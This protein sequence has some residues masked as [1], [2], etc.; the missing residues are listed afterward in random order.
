M[1]LLGSHAWRARATALL[2]AL[3]LGAVAV[4]PLAAQGSREGVP[5]AVERGDGRADPMPK[6]RG[7]SLFGSGDIATTGMKGVGAYSF[8]FTNYGPPLSDLGGIFISFY[9][10]VLRNGGWFN[11]YFEITLIAGAPR[12]EFR[13]IRNVH[14]AIG[15]FSSGNG[16]T[17]LWNAPLL[18]GIGEIAPSDNSLGT[19]FSGIQSTA[20][21]SC[22]DHTATVNEGIVAGS[23][24]L[25]GSDCPETWGTLGWQGPR[26]I[27]DTAFR[28]LQNELGDAFNW[29]YWRTDPAQR[30]GNLGNFSTFGVMT[31]HTQEMLQVYGGATPQGSGPSQVQ[32][33]P[34][35][36]DFRFEAASFSLPALANTY[37]Y[38]VL[39]INNS[40]DVYGTGI[41]YDS[42]YAGLEIG[43][44]DT[45][46][47][48]NTYYEPWRNAVM[49]A[50]NNINPNCNNARRSGTDTPACNAGVAGSGFTRGSSS[51]VMLKSPIGDMRNK[52]FT[53]PGAWNDPTH[54]RRADTITFNHGHKCGYGSCIGPGG[55]LEGSEQA[56]FGFISSTGANVL[57]GRSVNDLT[58]VQYFYTFRN[59][60]YPTRDAKFNS[61]APGLDKWDY[62][63]D[64][65][66]DTIYF[67]TC[68]E[69]TNNTN[70]SSQG[71]PSQCVSTWSD[72]TAGGFINQIG[73]VG[74]A[75]VAGP[76]ALKAGDT[77]SFIIAF[78]GAPDSASIEAATNN[79]IEGYLAFWAGPTGPPNPTVVATN[80]NR[81]AN[82]EPVVQITYSDAPEVWVDPFLMKYAA[83]LESSTAPDQVLLRTLNPTLVEDIRE[84]ASSGKNFKTLYV[85]KSCNGGNTWTADLDCIGDPAQDLA[86]NR[87]GNG[88]RPYRVIQADANGSLTNLFQDTEVT[89]GRTYLYSFVA[90]SRG[91]TAAV[92]DSLNGE[93]IS[94]TLVVADSILNP[95]NTSGPNVANVYVPISLAA[96][97]TPVESEVTRAGVPSTLPVTVVLS[98]SAQ[99]GD[100][101]AYF[102]NRFIV[103][104]STDLTTGITRSEVIVQ[105]FYPDAVTPAG[106]PVAGGAVASSQ[107]FMG[108]GRI[109]RGTGFEL[110]GSDTT[111]IA[112]ARLV[113][114]TLEA[115]GFL[116]AREGQ[117][118]FIST[119]PTIAESTPTTFLTSP[120]FPGFRLNID[121]ATAGTYVSGSEFAR[122]GGTDSLPA[123]VFN[124]YAVQWIEASSTRRN[125]ATG[126][127]EFTF[128]DDAY[129]PGA[130]FTLDFTNRAAVQQAV[131]AS[132]NARAKAD[133]GDTTA[134]TLALVQEFLPGAELVP[135]VFPFTVRNET[136]DRPVT[137][138]MIKRASNTVLLGNEADTIRVDVDSL[139][140]VPGDQ[141]VMIEMVSRDSV[142][143][144][145]NVVVDPVTQQPLQVTEPVVT[146]V[147]AVLGC[148]SP[149][150]SCNPLQLGTRGATG[151]LDY[152]AG[153]QLFVTY[154][155]GFVP[156]SQ[157]TVSISESTPT[158]SFSAEDRARIRVVPNPYIV[159]DEYDVVTGRNATSR[160][161]FSNVPAQ[162]QLRVYSVSGQFLQQLDWTA[163][164]LNGTGDLP[165]N[166]RSREGTDLA[167]GLYIWT[168]RAN[169][170]NG[171]SQLAR[172]KFVVIR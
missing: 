44:L 130:P 39:V 84:R 144:D 51:I 38:Q 106:T 6:R 69:F 66:A 89:A 115:L 164:D 102:G 146:F 148:G 124:S 33:Y 41:D 170:A 112:G 3:T 48:P 168:I 153:T 169:D 138:A 71:R 53:R 12:H 77:T 114:D 60:N 121:M 139:V 136:F 32:G 116:F 92:L 16:Y 83:D 82:N 113:V 142:D 171:K 101:T 17:V 158:N 72:S 128:D 8:S 30:G 27:P 76:F 111:D 135:A 122:K 42:L 68:S 120:L 143:E 40:A 105:T 117:P 94:R 7:F 108:T 141:F 162:G 127:Y 165:Y 167:S 150:A 118:L 99:G 137:L 161:Y 91:F 47:R 75:M 2:G 50:N 22:R 52:L 96:G 74:G 80:V 13:K 125:G 166:L 152:T 90:Q 95:V 19:F 159:Q 56:H 154:Q 78:N 4:A 15:E 73:N 55:A 36:L 9:P 29:Q 87:I 57:Y 126:Q 62:N 160:V 70:N 18:G 88:W 37:L 140:W 10:Q 45:P 129:G 1:R 61:F 67:D 97:T 85:Y 20:D 59:W 63:H 163:A 157:F 79:A 26:S 109:G 31:D 145:H 156:G 132:L 133:T 28:N 5:K 155:A 81:D 172:G 134:A 35:G 131:T 123:G 86:G 25:A 64:G 54:P 11:K 151:Y 93:L 46:Q 21:G 14:P 65:V 107:S 43:F 104:D 110:V 24:L 58:G 100:Y 98:Q 34:L 149:R 23:P 119:A 147:P 103:R 49:S